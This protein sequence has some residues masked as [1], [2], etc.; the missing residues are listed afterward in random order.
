MIPKCKL[1]IDKIIK[2]DVF[3]FIITAILF[4]IIISFSEVGGDDKTV[5]DRDNLS[6][7]AD[8]WNED[9]G[10]W[11]T[12]SSRVIINFL[13][14]SMIILP[15]Y[16]WVIYMGISMFVLLNALS[17][18]F[19]TEN[20]KWNNLFIAFLVMLLPWEPLSTAGW[21]ATTATYFGPLAF[22]IMALVPIKKEYYQEPI[23]WW[24]KFLYAIA[25]IY[26]TNAEQ[27]MVVALFCYLAAMVYFIVKK[28]YNCWYIWLMSIISVG[29]LLNVLFCPGNA[30]RKIEEMRKWYPSFPMLDTIDKIDIGLFATLKYVFI[31]GAYLFIIIACILM[32]YI[33]WKKFDSYF[34]RIISLLPT[35]I[36]IALG[37][38]KEV[39]TRCFPAFKYVSYGTLDEGLITPDTAQSMLTFFQYLLMLLILGTII[40]TIILVSDTWSQLLVSLVIAI[41]GLASRVAIGLSPTVFASSTRTYEMFFLCIL[42]IGVQI[43]SQHIDPGKLGV[44]TIHILKTVMIMGMIFSFLELGFLTAVRFIIY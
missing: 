1:I 23:K 2:S 37:P 35:C 14:R 44:K 6:T 28:R 40:I 21:I 8:C 16:I 25:L 3:I 15:R 26:G 42:M 12:W 19:V 10:R 7:V 36:L 4:G 13:S 39:I 11:F 9:W 17:M 38:F 31:D 24:K 30:V 5:L 43:F 34:Y 33:V 22:G 41:S 29:A 18:L 27:M 32:T 20:K